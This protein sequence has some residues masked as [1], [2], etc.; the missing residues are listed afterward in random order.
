[1][2]VNGF[3]LPSAFVN[4]CEATLRGEMPKSWA[5]KER[6]DA[7]GSP[8]ENFDLRID[9]DLETI[10][11]DTENREWRFRDDAEAT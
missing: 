10:T 1:M 6:V 8:W 7:Y 11:A 5:L 9:T 3:Q 2:V 4:L